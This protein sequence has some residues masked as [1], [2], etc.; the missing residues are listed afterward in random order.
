MKA[1]GSWL[2]RFRPQCNHNIQRKT[3]SIEGVFWYH[4]VIFKIS[5]V[6]P[7]FI[8]VE[9][10]PFGSVLSAPYC[11]L[12]YD[13]HRFFYTPTFCCVG[14]FNAVIY[15]LA[16]IFRID[17]TPFTKPVQAEAVT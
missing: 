9:F 5:L 8:C 10:L 17:F 11:S 6:F 13:P 2:K 1:S 4:T 7:S 15:I 3:P 12:A 14:W 16:H